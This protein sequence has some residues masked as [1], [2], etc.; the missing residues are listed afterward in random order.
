MSGKLYAG[1]TACKSKKNTWLSCEILEKSAKTV[2][3]ID[4][5]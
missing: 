3:F 5:P 1:S 4:L 2:Y